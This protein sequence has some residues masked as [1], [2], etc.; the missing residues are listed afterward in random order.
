MFIMPEHENLVT[1]LLDS[2]FTDVWCMDGRISNRFPYNLRRHGFTFDDVALYDYPPAIDA[3]R[4]AIGP[5]RRLHVICHCVG[6]I[7]FTMSLFAGKVHGITSVISNSV[8]LTPR[9]SWWSRVKLLVAPAFI[10]AFTPF[11]Y[12]DPNWAHDPGFSPGRLLSRLVSLAHRECDE[13][14]CHMVSFMWGDG[15]PAVFKHENLDPRTHAR[16]GQLFGGTSMNYHVHVRTMVRA[17][18]A[19][20]LK[21]DAA[22]FELPARYLTNAA[23]IE[24]PILFVTGSDNRVFF[25]SNIECHRR[26]EELVPGRHSLKVFQGYGHQDI[27]QGK[28]SAKDVFPTFLEFLKKP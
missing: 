13:P 8:A 2:G 14:A 24:T 1:T 22:S 9:V 10:Q 7:T 21:K 5:E 26:L 4:R 27:F 15:N 28:N 17:G 25:D 12:I 6:S 11:A 18:E 16:I 3:I 19:V 23:R 20:P